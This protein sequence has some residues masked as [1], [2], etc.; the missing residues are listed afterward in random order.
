[1]AESFTIEERLPTFN[2]IIDKAKRHWGAYKSEKQHYTEMIAWIVKAQ[3]KENYDCI[4]LKFRWYCA[5]K[6]TDKDNIM[7]GQKYIIDGIVSAG[8]IKDDN[9]AYIDR[10]EHEF[11]H[12]NKNPRTEVIIE[13]AK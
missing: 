3:I 1:M 8:I 6:R 9:W 7:A 12:D 13:R 11:Y 5:D 4:N 2:K 10:I